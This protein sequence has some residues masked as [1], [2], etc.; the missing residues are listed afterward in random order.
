MAKFKV[1]LRSGEIK[2]VA[3]AA[4]GANAFWAEAVAEHDPSLAN[5]FF[6]AQA[7]EAPWGEE[8]LVKDTA[9]AEFVSIDNAV[10]Q[11]GA[12]TSSIKLEIQDED[13]NLISNNISAFEVDST[14]QFDEYII[15]NGVLGE[16]IEEG[17]LGV[18]EIET[19][20][21]EFPDLVFTAFSH[22]GGNFVFGVTYKG[23]DVEMLDGSD[24]TVS[25]GHGS[26]VAR[27]V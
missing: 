3:F 9:A 23:N 27:F 24:D 1:T 8:V 12:L 2:T 26:I 21:F 17:T 18:W 10:S 15:G 25:E 6:H 5:Q 19:D 13:G 16:R 22:E 7:H 11:R 20:F 4:S 14:V